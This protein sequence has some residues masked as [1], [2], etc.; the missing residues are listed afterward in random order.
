M[1]CSTAPPSRSERRFQRRQQLR[2]RAV[3]LVVDQGIAGCRSDDLQLERAWFQPQSL[4]LILAEEQRLAVLDENLGFGC[5]FLAGDM[6]EHRVVEDD[7]V[8]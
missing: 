3:G 6:L 2:Q 4:L 8:L 7:A 5:H 1:G